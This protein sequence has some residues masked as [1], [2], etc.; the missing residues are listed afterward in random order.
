GLNRLDR[1]SNKFTRFQYDATD[2]HSIASNN[3][4]EILVRRN[5]QVWVT[6]E[7]G[8]LQ[9]FDEKN[10]RFR[11]FQKPQVSSNYCDAMLE[12][13]E[14]E[15]WLGTYFGLNKQGE[16]GR[17]SLTDSLPRL[18]G[19]PKVLKA[20]AEDASGNLW[21]GMRDGG[22][23]YFEKKTGSIV[24]VP[25]SPDEEREPKL[26]HV[27]DI[28]VDSH[29]NVWVGT[30]GGLFH[31]SPKQLAVGSQQLGVRDSGWEVS[32]FPLGDA[33]RALS[34]CE[35]RDGVVWVG[36]NA[37]V[38]VLVPRH[39]Q[40]QHLLPTKP[41][42]PATQR[43]GVTSTAVASAFGGKI[44]VGTTR[45]L[46][47]FDP[48]QMHF[49][50]DFLEKHPALR[51][52][53]EEN[54]AAI[55]TDRQGNLWVS[56]ITDFNTGFDVFCYT[57]QRQ[58]VNLSNRC[59]P[60]RSHVTFSI[61]EDGEGNLWFAN[62]AGLVRFH[63]ASDSLQV[64]HHDP[65]RQESLG[66]NFAN[67][68]FFSKK[69]G[70]WVGLND[71]GLDHFD[72][73]NER[74]H[75]Y[76]PA[77]GDPTSISH[78]QVLHI[79]E[80]RAGK[81]W[82]GTAGGLNCFDPTTGKFQNWFSRHGLPDELVNGLLQDDSG[83]L[84][85]STHHALSFF[86]AERQVFLNFDKTDGIAEKEFWDRT[87]YRDMTGRMYF[88]GELG[89]TVFHPDSIRTN[90]F[91]PPV[92]FTD[93]LLFNKE[94]VPDS[95]SRLLPEHVSLAK[96]ITLRPDQNV[97]TFHFAA[98]SYISPGKT[99][100]SIKM[101][102]FEDDWQPIGNRT[103]ATYTNLA[104]GHYT[105]RVR[106]ANGDGIWNESGASIE[107]VVL[108]PW[109]RTWWALGIFAA[110][111]AGA[112]WLFHRASVKRHLE[113]AETHRL[114]ELD[115]FKTRFYTNITHEFRTPLTLILGPVEKALKNLL[116]LEAPDLE[117]VKR[118]GRRLLRLVNQMLDLSKLDAG[119]LKIH[120]VQGDVVAF[121]RY[122]AES[123]HSLA[124]SK[125]VEVVFHAEP[126]QFVMDF[127]PEKL[128]DIVGNLLSNALKFTP[129]GGRV[130]LKLEIGNWEIGKLGGSSNFPI[131]QFLISISDTG[132][133]IPS[134]KLPHI[135]DRFYTGSMNGEEGT[136]IG[137]A[138]TKELVELLG[139]TISVE[140]NPDSNR[141]GVGSLFKV[142]LPVTHS[143]LTPLLGGSK[144]APMF[145]S[146]VAADIIEPNNNSTIQQSNNPLVLII[147]DNPDVA[148]FIAGCLKNQFQVEFAANGREG[149]E[150][151]LA[152]VPDLIVSDVMM[153]EMDGFEA[154]RLLKNDERTS[155][156]PVILLTARADLASRLEGLG[157]GADAYLAKP[158]NEEELLVHVEKLLELRRKL[159]AFY[160]RQ[161]GL[162]EDT[163]VPAE[164]ETALENAFL[165]RVRTCL[166]AHLDD[167]S[168]SVEDLSH[169]VGMSHSQLH[170][171][172]VALTGHSTQKFVRT[173]RLQKAKVLLRTSELTVAEVAYQTGFSEPGY[174][175]KVFAR[176]F[177]ATPT[178]WRG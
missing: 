26:K 61:C 52:F 6:T 79:L 142:T 156:I 159:Q 112:A 38:L 116:P 98:L 105:F 44:W 169:S 49:H 30:D 101:E 71:A 67:R 140:S 117:L 8:G 96:K 60:F 127:D 33:K 138:L 43:R 146:A 134:E 29:R 103:E 110:L 11:R 48:E 165:R 37:G 129:A 80:D 143:P 31:L 18:P 155:H 125:N 82:L 1:R 168:F 9:F 121:L 115:E 108:P 172:M 107:V 21:L 23:F 14:G 135:F 177:G 93:F 133:G 178:E 86:D 51:H 46:F 19:Q 53:D 92:V 27:W 171:K 17:F 10:A 161:A 77:S 90:P 4:N 109:W 78:R 24:R 167:A 47:Q 15:L 126:E 166:E 13:S 88:G 73:E 70:L 94:V 163:A 81:L 170:R 104:P 2:P 59:V 174:F 69:T 56:T 68:V 95:E 106:A 65:A 12:S 162:E 102:G 175:T 75:H 130:A 32:A 35:S 50:R 85:V 132:V 144:T 36:T 164:A 87:G 42:E 118:S 176:E 91:V 63:V 72:F 128:T 3:I 40:F 154:T 7:G 131:S 122:V 114:Q 158:F 157:R 66:S 151:A 76:Q 20:L 84:W 149:I 119:H 124:E 111:A 113:Q 148:R 139:G 28:L 99:Q 153:P 152:L 120:S 62:G 25:L 136:G 54:I 160:L 89:L 137:L 58:L 57:P 150:K 74:F 34:I 145:R 41:G 141:E 147:E 100:F 97:F 83:R 173:V 45:G 16:D 64:F 5:G 39:K 55:F 123:F 22:L